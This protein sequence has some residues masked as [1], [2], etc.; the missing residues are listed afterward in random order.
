VKRFSAVSD[1][2]CW[3]CL[4]NARHSAIEFIRSLFIDPATKYSTV[5]H[6]FPRLLRKWVGKCAVV[7]LPNL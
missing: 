3:G 6:P 1:L 4:V 2:F 5:P 7:D